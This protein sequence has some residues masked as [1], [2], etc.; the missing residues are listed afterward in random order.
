M[1]A[2]DPPIISK[3][4]RKANFLPMTSPIRPKTRAPSGRTANPTAKVASVLRNAAVG[5]APGDN[6]GETPEDVEVVPLDHRPDR[7]CGNH[8]PD[9]LR[10]VQWM[11]ARSSRTTGVRD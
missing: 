8:L 11:R 4:A 1:A 3:V 5:L 9:S 2:V 6:G 10:G 7:R